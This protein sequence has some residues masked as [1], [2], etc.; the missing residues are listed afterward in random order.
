MMFSKK[1]AETVLKKLDATTSDCDDIMGVVAL[2]PTYRLRLYW[3]NG[4]EALPS[5]VEHKWRSTLRLK[6]EEFIDLYE[7]P[8]S[9]PD[10]LT[11]T[12]ERLG[13]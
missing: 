8:L 12:R 5:F 2:A 13:L 7:C 11:L 1:A 9:G 4:H 10:A 6:V 3:D